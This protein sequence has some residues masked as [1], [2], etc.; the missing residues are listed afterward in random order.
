MVI[1]GSSK[2]IGDTVYDDVR[3]DD[4]CCDLFGRMTV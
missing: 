3:Y 4:V 1:L 2:K